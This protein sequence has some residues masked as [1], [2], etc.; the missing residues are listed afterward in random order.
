M[1]PTR[2]LFN[3]FTWAPMQAIRFSWSFNPPT[4]FSKLWTLGHKAKKKS[5]KST[6]SPAI[7]H[8]I[9]WG[10]EE[11]LKG[12]CFV[13][14][15]LWQT[16][17][18]QSAQYKRNTSVTLRRYSWVSPHCSPNAVAP[19]WPGSSLFAPSPMLSASGPA[20]PVA[21]SL[22]HTKWRRQSNNLLT[23]RQFVW[24]LQVK[25]RDKCAAFFCGFH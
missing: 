8:F 22:A 12:G 19:V 16:H 4:I 5:I 17:C 23:N 7:T 10:A 6:F 13:L 15:K 2:P 3:F 20:L 11:L 21:L 24:I 25:W 18:T 9:H 1:V 14:N